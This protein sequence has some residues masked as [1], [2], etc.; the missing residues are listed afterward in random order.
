MKVVNHE[1]PKET[2]ESMFT[3]SKSLFQLPLEEK[4]KLYSDDL[5]K[6]MRLSTSFNVNNEKV[7]SWR[8]CLRL[9]C[10]PL[11]KYVPEWPSKPTSFK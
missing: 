1:M 9:H 8:D 7:H 5:S 10:H 3:V 11:E 6:T 4:L 2:M